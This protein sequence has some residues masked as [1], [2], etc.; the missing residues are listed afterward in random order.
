LRI[1]MHVIEV[2]SFKDS[3]KKDSERL[4][5]DRRRDP[6]SNI[7]FIFRGKLENLHA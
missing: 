5:A 6:E 7:L 3:H 2:T 1:Y 4:T